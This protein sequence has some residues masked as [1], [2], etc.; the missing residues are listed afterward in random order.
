MIRSNKI[1]RLFVL[2]LLGF[3]SGGCATMWPF[4]HSSSS[5]LSEKSDE[6]DLTDNPSDLHPDKPAQIAKPKSMTPAQLELKQA[7]LWN[8]L[9]DLEEEVRI[10]RERIKLLEQ[11]LLT[12]I[13]PEE[14]KST[15]SMKKPKPKD[16]GKGSHPLL[17]DKGVK[18]HSDNT[19]LN[20]ASLEGDLPPV[21]VGTESGKD[22]SKDG[23]AKD[24]DGSLVA[25]NPEGYKVR[26]QVAKDYFQGSRFGLSIA[27]LAQIL[28]AFGQDIGGGEP[29]VLLG[30]AYLNMKEFSTAKNELESVIKDFPKSSW[31][32]LA[33]IEL[34][35]AYA[36]MNLRERA[37]KELA[38]VATAFAGKEEGDMASSELDKM[39]GTL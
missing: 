17:G 26:M 6:V 14:L 38:Q 3:S 4:D 35:R 24:G 39:K 10:Q 1:S 25:R 19:M 32:G 29:R 23:Q 31:E 20:N 27:E 8:K 34:A 18:P 22:S 37:R 11:G 16:R 15:S 36:G 30:R 2:V 7:R 5:K 28:K 21:V 9:E 33:R 13:A 12:G